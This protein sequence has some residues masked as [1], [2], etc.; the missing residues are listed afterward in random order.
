M[1][2]K[3][4]VLY[5]HSDESHLEQRKMLLQNNGYEVLAASTDQNDI[6]HINLRRVN[7][8]VFECRDD[9][10]LAR[11]MKR[12][13]PNIPIVLVANSLDLP[14]LATE[15][16][17]ALVASFDGDQFLLDTL[18]FLLEVKPGQPYH[19]AHNNTRSAGRRL[20]ESTAL[21]W[22]ASIAGSS[23]N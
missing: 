7:A 22:R 20:A 19:D 16:I 23:S 10:A 4:N 21:A 3:G 14:E 1:S 9:S 15:N 6:T 11:E 8:I 2:R 12:S 18:H 17:D 5:L 13:N